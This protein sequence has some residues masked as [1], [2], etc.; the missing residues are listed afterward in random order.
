MT[1]MLTGAEHVA[2][3]ICTMLTWGI[4]RT[5]SRGRS[6]GEVKWTFLLGLAWLEFFRSDYASVFKFWKVNSVL[7]NFTIPLDN[8]AQEQSN[9]GSKEEAEA[10]QSHLKTD[11][12]SYF[13]LDR[14]NP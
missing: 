4:D 12:P 9:Q 14:R 5:V 13:I 11:C 7:L 10:T 2:S 8:H 6:E 1:A 3:Y